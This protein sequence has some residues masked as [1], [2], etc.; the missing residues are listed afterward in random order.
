[1][2]E[3]GGNTVNSQFSHIFLLPKLD[4]YYITK[5]RNRIELMYSNTYVII[6]NLVIVRLPLTKHIT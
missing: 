1:M 3:N 6:L 4:G 2:L 5:Y